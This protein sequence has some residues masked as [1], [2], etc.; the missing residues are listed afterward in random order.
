MAVSDDEFEQLFEAYS[1]NPGSGALSSALVAAADRPL[2]RS[3]VKALGLADGPPH[4]PADAAPGSSAEDPD[5]GGSGRRSH[6][7][8]AG[9]R[10]PV[11]FEA[12][13]AGK[14]H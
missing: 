10:Y 14:G 7:R 8:G 5:A 6:G 1:K 9:D 11:A 13:A 2:R 12:S 3:V 4:D